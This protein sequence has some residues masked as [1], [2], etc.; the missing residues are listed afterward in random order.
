MSRV[1]PRWMICNNYYSKWCFRK[2]AQ[3]L[4]VRLTE[5]FD[6]HWEITE[7]ALLIVGWGKWL[8]M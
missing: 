2:M 8:K 4:M 1:G 6:T 3:C 5:L 7:N